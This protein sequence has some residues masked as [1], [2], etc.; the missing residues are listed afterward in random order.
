MTMLR[1]LIF[2][3]QHISHIV[4][5]VC[6]ELV[7]CVVTVINI[8]TSIGLNKMFERSTHKIKGRQ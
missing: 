6:S 8:R 1:L 5:G 2:Y 3:D 4:M 7:H